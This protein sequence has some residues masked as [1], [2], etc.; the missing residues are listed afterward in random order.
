[1]RSPTDR[2]LAERARLGLS[3]KTPIPDLLGLVETVAQVPVILE[4][5]GP[6]GI[7]GAYLVRRGV[8]FVLLNSTSPIVRLRFTLAHEY[9]HHVLGHGLSIDKEITFDTTQPQ[10][11]VQ[12]NAFAAEFLLPLEA[13]DVWLRGRNYPGP[14]LRLIVDLARDF[15]VSAQVACYRMQSADRL[16]VRT[17]R[18]LERAIQAG[19]HRAVEVPRRPFLQD[20]LRDAKRRLRRLPAEAEYLL[21]RALEQELIDADEVAAQL[22]MTRDQVGERLA[23]VA[24]ERRS[25][26]QE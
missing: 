17:V 25:E 13:L 18:D 14:D 7:A 4:Q 9:G 21:V 2:A 1:V 16:S 12:A 8:P 11:E 10:K 24:A 3:S 19:E 20:S 26:D 5:L 22:R 15:L 23:Q 6:R